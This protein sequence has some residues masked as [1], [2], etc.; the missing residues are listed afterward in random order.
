MTLTDTEVVD[1][2]KEKQHQQADKNRTASS[3]HKKTM[4]GV[5]HTL[6]HIPP[7]L[8]PF[9]SGRRRIRKRTA[10]LFTSSKVFEM[11][12]EQDKIL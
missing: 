2:A 3:A 12:N 11:L 8:E 7:H 6:T 9:S 10:S 5:R 4:T 1:M